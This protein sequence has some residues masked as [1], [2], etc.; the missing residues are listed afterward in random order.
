MIFN[1][2]AWLVTLPVFELLT[3]TQ[4][5]G[6]WPISMHRGR[7]PQLG[8]PSNINSPLCKERDIRQHLDPDDGAFRAQI[9]VIVIHQ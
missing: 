9:T 2:A 5:N 8:S 7:D 4:W 1:M 6:S 3:L